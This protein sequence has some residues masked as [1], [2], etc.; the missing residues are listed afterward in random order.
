MYVFTRHPFIDN[1]HAFWNLF[2]KG[3]LLIN[4]D[5]LG[6]G[7]TALLIKGSYVLERSGEMGKL[8]SILYETSRKIS[9]RVTNLR[10][11][12]PKRLPWRD[13]RDIIFG[14]YFFWTIPY[15]LFYLI[16]AFVGFSRTR[17]WF[18]LGISGSCGI[19][20]EILGIA[21]C[22]DYYRGV[23]LEA[24]YLAVPFGTKIF[25]VIIVSHFF[26]FIASYFLNPSNFTI[27]G[28]FYDLRLWYG[29]HF[30]NFSTSISSGKF[31]RNF[32]WCHVQI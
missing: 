2:W 11:K 23:N 27:R 21:H 17:N 7:T 9:K 29:S 3:S 19:L 18:C 26:L 12:N 13:Q 10:N 24:I 1:L 22:I 8:G 5:V 6:S 25:G 15:G 31:F 16:G 14:R 30:E 28:N 20:I 32:W 4:G